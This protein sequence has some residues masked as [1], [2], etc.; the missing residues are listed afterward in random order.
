MADIYLDEMSQ[1]QAGGTHDVY[2]DEV[3]SPSPGG[4]HDV[5]L[6][7]VEQPAQLRMTREERIAQNKRAIARAQ[8]PGEGETGFWG[9]VG[10]GLAEGVRGAGRALKS[11]GQG[12]LGTVTS[13]V[14]LAGTPV[15]MA[16]GWDGIHRLADKIDSSYENFGRDAL[17]SEY[18]ENPDGWGYALGR[19][20]EKVAN[21]AGSLAGLGGAGK[22]IGVADKA[23]KTAKYAKTAKVVENLLPA[24]FGND[25]A[26]RAYDTARANGKD[27]TQ[28]A[29]LAGLNGAIHF[30][31]FKAFE[32]QSLKKMLN[33]GPDVEVMMPK[34]ADAAAET[35]GQS[36]SSLV[37]GTRNGMMKYIAAERGK[38]ALKAGGIMGLQN[39]L[40]DP[41][42]Q[43]AEGADID[44]IDLS[45]ML[46]AGAEGVGEGALMEGLM[47]GAAIL[48]SQKAA[49]KFIADKFFRG[50][51]YE[52]L[53]ADG[54]MHKELGLLESPQGRMALMKQNPAATEH[55]LDVIDHG[56][57]PT[58]AELDAAFLPPDMTPEE[59]R[60]FHDDWQRDLEPYVEKAWNADQPRETPAPAA[61]EAGPSREIL[62][63]EDAQRAKND[64]QERYNAQILA[65]EEAKARAGQAAYDQRMA[66]FEE[67]RAGQQPKPET[68][69]QEKANETGNGA[70]EAPAQPEQETSG[71]SEAREVGGAETPEPP[72]AE[73]P[74]AGVVEP[75][76]ESATP[77]TSPAPTAEPPAQPVENAPTIAPKPP[78]AQSPAKPAE[79]VEA[80]SRASG[81][82]SGKKPVNRFSATSRAA[83]DDDPDSGSTG[84]YRQGGILKIPVDFER[85][86][87]G[88]KV[89][90]S[91]DDANIT[92]YIKQVLDGYGGL[93]MSKT[94]KIRLG[95]ERGVPKELR[96]LFGT[97]FEAGQND[98]VLQRLA[99]ELNNPS[100]ADMSPEQLH[101]AILDDRDNYAQW[102]ERKRRE[103]SGERVETP[104]ERHW[105]EA[106]EADRANTAEIGGEEYHID[107]LEAK[108]AADEQYDNAF[109]EVDRHDGERETFD[110]FS[111][112]RLRSLKTGDALRFDHA[113]EAWE[114]V[115]YDR[116]GDVLTLMP[117][118]MR[119][120]PL[121]SDAEKA[122][123][124]V[125]YAVTPDGIR[126]LKGE[127]NGRENEGRASEDISGDAQGAGDGGSRGAADAE[128]RDFALDGGTAEEIAAEQRRIRDRAEIERRLNAPL[129][130]G[131]G[132]MGQSLLD[133]GGQEG[134]D[135]FNQTVRTEPAQKSG[136]AGG[137]DAAS[138]RATLEKAADDA[139]K[140]Y[141]KLTAAEM[142]G[143]KGR[144]AAA[145]IER[146][147]RALLDFYERN[148]IELDE[149]GNPVEAKPAASGSP[150]VAPE[151]D[152]KAA[153]KAEAQT[154]GAPKV[155]PKVDPKVALAA[156]K[157]LGLLAYGSDA[158]LRKSLALAKAHGHDQVASDIETIIA[159][160][161]AK[162]SVPARK[163]GELRGRA[164]KSVQAYGVDDI[165]AIEDGGG[166][167]DA[168]KPKT[169]KVSKGQISMQDAYDLFNALNSN[170]ETGELMDK[171][172][173]VMKDADIR[174]A[175][176]HLEEN[177]RETKRERGET[178]SRTLGVEFGGNIELDLA[179]MNSSNAA[180]FKANTMLHE[181]I[182]AATDY[183]ISLVDGKGRKP[184]D[185]VVSKELR[186][187]VKDLHKIYDTVKDDFSKDYYLEYASQN[188]HEFI[189]ELS[190]Q[191]V[192]NALK[193]RNL[194]TRVVDA[195]RRV[196]RAF[197]GGAQESNAYEISEDVLDRFLSN[198]DREAFDAWR[199]SPD[200]SIDPNIPRG[201][202]YANET[203]TAKMSV[204]GMD[205]R[206]TARRRRE[207]GASRFF[208]RGEEASDREREEAYTKW[209][210][211]LPD[212]EKRRREWE[213][214][215]NIPM[216]AWKSYPDA[217]VSV[218]DGRDE[219]AFK[220]LTARE[221]RHYLRDKY[222]GLE[223]EV[224][225]D[226]TVVEFTADGL[227]S[228]MK[229]RGGHK[230]PLHVLDKL[231]E[232]SHFTRFEGNDGQAKHAHLDGQLVYTSAVRLS[233][234][235]YGVE[236]KLDVPTG[237][238]KARF[239]GQTLKTKIADAVLSAGPR[240]EEPLPASRSVASARE[241]VRLG[242][243]ANTEASTPR[244]VP[245][246][247][248]EGKGA[249]GG[250]RFFNRGEEAG[251]GAH[252]KRDDKKKPSP[253]D[254]AMT[255]GER[256]RERWQDSD[257]VVRNVQ[258][259]IGGVEDK[260]DA[261][262]H[263]AAK[264]TFKEDGTVDALGSTDVYNAKDREN[265][266][267]E[268]GMRDI[269]SR[270]D[271]IDK[272]LATNGITP[273]QFDRYLYAA[274]AEERNRTVAER[275][276][277][278]YDPTS[279]EGSGLSEIEA[280]KILSSP[281]VQRKRTAY[282]DAAKMVYDMNDANLRRRLES[283]R[284]SQELYDLLTK[285][286]KRYVPLRTDVE[287]GENAA[288]NL[289]TAGFRSSEF[290]TAEGREEGSMADSPYAFARL[291]AEQG[292]R[293]SERNIVNTTFA[294]LVRQSI[295]QGKPI[296]EITEGRDAG[297][298]VGWTF[299]FADGD[300]V[301]VG[302][303]GKLAENRQDIVL[304]K[305]DG[306]LKAIRVNPG[307][308]G[309]GL[310]LAQAV[311]GENVKR[312][313]REL[314]WL[315]KATRW[316]SAMRT[317]YSPEFMFTNSLADHLEAAQ[318]LVGRY[319]IGSGTALAAKAAMWEAKNLKSLRAY[320]NGGAPTGYVKEA[321]DG[322][323][324]IKGGVA[325]QGF[326]GEVEAIKSN[327][328]RFVRDAK[329]LYRMNPKELGGFVWDGMKDLVSHANELVE[330]S[331][332]IG[333]YSA[334]RE[335][336][337]SVNEAVKFARDATVN[338]NRRGTM[339]PW[340]NGLYMFANASVQGAVRSFQAMGDRHGAQLVSLLVA[341]GVAKAVLDHYFGNDDEREKV[342]GRNARNASEYEKK[343]ILGIPV[344]G[345]KQIAA[346]RMRGPY[347]AIPYLAQTFTNVALGETEAEDAMHTVFREVTDQASDL[348]SGNGVVNDK[349]GLDAA[350]VGQTLAPS[351][352][353]PLVQLW[354]GKDY[355]GDWRTAKSYDQDK[356][357]SSNGKRNTAEAYKIAAQSLNWLTGGNENRKG[358]IDVAPEDLQ[359][360]VEFLGGGIGRDIHNVA[361]TAKNVAQIAAGETPER[362]LS[363]AP[364][365]RTLLREYPESTARYYDAIDE[366]ERDKY[367]I[368]K[369]K[370]AKEIMA[371]AK[372]KP[373]LSRGK[374]PLDERIER[375][376]ELMHLERGERKI[377]NRWVKVESVSDA[378]RETYRKMRLKLQAAILNALRK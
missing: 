66:E 114:V 62:S 154:P 248:G 105:R 232:D 208:D 172:F 334:L 18:G 112:D 4:V 52:V 376:K 72:R 42:M 140:A 55:V 147:D 190:N 96:P 64:A 210:A 346:L 102:A 149:D 181:M 347:A 282:E 325:S 124:L 303:S 60:K 343:H 361:A 278:E 80:P 304:F 29:A 357:L 89:V 30:L 327:Y 229:K 119:S 84:L 287:N 294:N 151:K 99:D 265:G 323:L 28:A 295:A 40:S 337:V 71:Q 135:L 95:G 187:A 234:G 246:S 260:I 100:I 36:F 200:K 101:K 170:K 307:A 211:G 38:G 193:K 74:D 196:L 296:G 251:G 219:P 209:L 289:S 237:Y 212:S 43:V 225:A 118:G 291:Q 375:V 126:E 311:T 164:K 97:S 368:K 220:N 14:R 58:E 340:F 203:R 39:M 8:Q 82:K 264:T 6:D 17:M 67:A 369:A 239:K 125:K 10:E 85:T 176:R 258:D 186:D 332:R 1:P 106:E 215:Q 217:Q 362:T 201:D 144:D 310:A 166:F 104:E 330:N 113:D 199:D 183:A 322:G 244:I 269:Q 235:V 274:H 78:E 194:W 128:G 207:R 132:E 23:L 253:I 250:E 243:V 53:G 177:S 159:D 77:P 224:K 348:V 358:M 86:A 94:G 173:N 109:A 223:V 178:W 276:G 81:A 326:A 363:Q 136:R 56:G 88:G 191:S 302:G 24:M 59:L 342:G 335:R 76:A 245:N 321:I 150:A 25:A 49:E 228:T 184:K 233:D 145:E 83:Y 360:V 254:R 91:T 202:L 180:Q 338:F 22:V 54:M 19:A 345:G 15:R 256:F 315:P 129:K 146:A 73:A 98:G 79:G 44:E 333:I 108:T 174:L 139:R 68:P 372:G 262:G 92:D 27:K 242:D 116:D 313:A 168:P 206:E 309:R 366:Y 26:V 111:R 227:K 138:E 131:K 121:F 20:G 75:P 306:K 318:A 148:G 214:K 377:R 46:K 252:F 367:E 351:L 329:K 175:I 120:N 299:H 13:A 133:L 35:G 204:D 316:L 275:N 115:D 33:I 292:V 5:Y 319:G 240:S 127:R 162:A 123:S 34:W 290:M 320:I 339:M 268:A 261:S 272:V 188:V 249:D 231:V 122:E 134:G 359:L 285:Q 171:V 2:L 141:A 286:W 353:D 259:E 16:T 236:L 163:D 45:R 349:G 12:V 51:D 356:P 189:A 301:Q 152:A 270:T 87:P 284:I 312:W 213:K 205:V 344:G 293:G 179:Y 247:G 373:Y 308:E 195:I 130:T 107:E 266:Y 3:E 314:A 110:A 378:Q 336:G 165:E 50:R 241:T 61:S 352:A 9:A 158:Q 371:V 279:G 331:T 143:A 238:D 355:K 297:R 160:R 374:T 137:T 300:R 169:V 281:E 103:L 317:Q 230:R 161:K 48:R 288:F 90:F 341:A 218:V 57:K 47:G 182:H 267:L 328:D 222:Q 221:L 157:R 283:G 31:G 7:E 37:R 273:E 198:F 257:V 263:T 155:A 255:R 167:G 365:L 216:S 65:R 69:T 185:V 280:K 192:R 324:L 277:R 142:V 117:E 370:T 63:A 153:A 93:V 271:K 226:G 156:A 11:A 21:V 305:E 32:N 197:G 70:D 298:G 364:L 350:L 41:V 354:T